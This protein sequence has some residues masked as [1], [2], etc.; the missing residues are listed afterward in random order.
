MHPDNRDRQNIALNLTMK[1][2]ILEEDNINAHKS[3]IFISSG[4]AENSGI[5]MYFI[6]FSVPLQLK[7]ITKTNLFT[8][9]QA[10][11]EFHH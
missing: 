8:N 11:H 5:P 10:E 3:Y 1:R 2:P 6:P 4:Q 9:L 7:S